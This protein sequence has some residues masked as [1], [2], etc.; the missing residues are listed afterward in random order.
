MDTEYRL[1]FITILM[2][3]EPHFKV[4]AYLNI[5]NIVSNIKSELKNICRLPKRENVIN[6]KE[7]FVEY[8]AH[9]QLINK[10]GGPF[11]GERKRQLFVK[12]LIN[13]IAPEMIIETGTF[14]GD[15]TEY[16]SEIYS[17]K[18][19]SIENNP[20]YWGYSLARF[21]FK[22]NVHVTY[23]D[24]RKTLNKLLAQV[25]RNKILFIYLDAHWGADLPLREEIDIIYS[26]CINS[27]VMID[28]FK[29]PGDEKYGYDRYSQKKYIS[30]EYLSSEIK[31]H[32]LMTYIPN[33]PATEES[34]SRRGW[35]ILTKEKSSKDYLSKYTD[36]RLFT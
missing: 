29:I 33:Y 16:L 14:R 30:L 6:A 1:I 28:D 11:N 23:G 22:Y 36:I 5:R 27:L 13:D 12:R 35:A 31:N 21:L 15:T 3:K 24:S 8:F 10:W 7:G 20:Y 25:D 26:T 4:A 19:Y 9:P 17:G 32:Q 2:I 34:G 18:I